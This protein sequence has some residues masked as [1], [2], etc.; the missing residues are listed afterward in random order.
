[1]K[2]LASEKWR[3]DIDKAASPQRLE[4]AIELSA[5]RYPVANLFCAFHRRAGSWHEASP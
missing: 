3:S 1:M 5:G 2:L 4:E